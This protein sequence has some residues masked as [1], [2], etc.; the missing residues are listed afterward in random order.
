MNGENNIYKGKLLSENSSF[1]IN[2][3]FKMLRTNLFYTAKGEKCPVYGITSTFAHSGK[4]LIISNLAVSFAQLEK[5]VLLIDCDLRKSMVHKVFDIDKAEG[6]SELLASADSSI[7]KYIK[8]TKYPNLSIITAGGMPPNPAELLASAR[9]G[10]FLEFMKQ[11]FDIIFIDLPP[12]AIVT[13]AV[14]ITEHVTGYLYVVRSR[15]DD[16]KTLRNAIGTME[17][18]DANIIG[19][20]LNDVDPKSSRYGRYGRYGKYGKYEKYGYG[21]SKS[22]SK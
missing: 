14:V 13:D 9:M 4:S 6:I 20:I 5:K 19:L 2:E 10:K 12:V 1:A 8:K 21:S 17:Q 11:H 7:D 3:A 18:M 15:Q 22:Q 16:A